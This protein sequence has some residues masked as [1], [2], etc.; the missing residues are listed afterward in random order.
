MVDP[1]NSAYH[2]A[3]AASEVTLFDQSRDRAWILVAVE[4][5]KMCMSLNEADGRSPFRLGTLYQL[6]ADTA[7]TAEARNQWLARATE[8][9]AMAVARDPYSPRNYVALGNLQHLRGD[10]HQARSSFSQAI[11]YEPNYLPARVLRIKVDLALGNTIGAREDYQT[12]LEIIERWTGK[13]S[14][15]L[16]QQF[17]NVDTGEL[18]R[19]FPS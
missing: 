10:L 4:E 5:M 17:L 6:L 15:A 13:A 14:T 18:K 2:D 1:W 11:E 9:Y 7:E 12:L 19:L 3:L 8:S 16:E